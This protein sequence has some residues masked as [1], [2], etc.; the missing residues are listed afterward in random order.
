MS[1]DQTLPVI[2]DWQLGCADT[3]GEG[4]A[5]D[6]SFPQTFVG[7]ILEAVIAGII[8][9]IV[10][11]ATMPQIPETGSDAMESNS[12]AEGGR[13]ST[14]E[15]PTATPNPGGPRSAAQCDHPTP[16]G[17]G[18]LPRSRCNALTTA[19][20]SFIRGFRPANWGVCGAFGNAWIYACRRGMAHF[21]DRHQ[22][23][24]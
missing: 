19:N 24:A 10:Q 17:R 14:E 6:R 16:T 7:A 4:S 22:S 13:V 11:R 15:P 20:A 5:M 2:A 12:T 9:M 18:H 8:V 21:R 3:K 23:G 1:A